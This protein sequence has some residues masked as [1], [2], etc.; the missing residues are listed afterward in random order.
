MSEY[1]LFLI[2]DHSVFPEDSTDIFFLP[3]IVEALLGLA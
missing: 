2:F 3:V 1:C